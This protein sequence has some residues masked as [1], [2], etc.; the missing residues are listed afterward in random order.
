MKCYYP[1]DKSGN[2][3]GFKT[4]E[5]CIYDTSGTNLTNKL[6]K[7]RTDVNGKAAASHG[8]HVPTP[9]TANN[10]IYLRNDNTWHTITPSDIGA[11]ASSHSHSWDSITSKPSLY[12][13]SQIDSKVDA[14]NSNI[15]NNT[16]G[17]IWSGKSMYIIEHKNAFPALNSN[18]QRVLAPLYDIY[19]YGA[20]HININNNTAS[21][22][23]QYGYDGNNSYTNSNISNMS[24]GIP[25]KYLNPASIL[26]VSGGL[27]YEQKNSASATGVYYP[28]PYFELEDNPGSGLDVYAVKVGTTQSKDKCNLTIRVHKHTHTGTWV[29][30]NDNYYYFYF[31]I[32]SC[33]SSS[34]LQE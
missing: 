28:L 7:L 20:S 3:I 13:T 32:T 30:N 10:K 22:E 14:I 25:Y 16:Q 21:S 34:M 8:N 31:K 23:W 4:P 27:I 29:S 11:A 12:T 15:A 24:Y 5:A 19:V 2:R 9:Q 18:G 1:T 33:G 26:T 6:N 17:V